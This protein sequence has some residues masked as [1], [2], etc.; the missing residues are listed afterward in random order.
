MLT[1]IHW[2]KHRVHNEDAREIPRE[3]KGTETL[4]EIHQY[5][6]TSTPRAPWKYTTNQNKKT[7]KKNKKKKSHSGTCGSK[8][9][10]C[11]RMA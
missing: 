1:V 11:Q 3:L 6:L 10:M 9:Y 8:L 5:E 2:T 7:K 4:K